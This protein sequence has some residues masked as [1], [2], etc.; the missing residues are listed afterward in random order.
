MSVHHSVHAIVPLALLEAIRNLDTP[1]DDGLP[2]ELASETLTKRLGL[3]STVAAQIERYR[4][5]ATRDT[6]VLSD[7]AIQVFRLVGRRPDATLV[8][9]DAGRR[10]ARYAARRRNGKVPVLR[11]IMPRSLRLRLGVRAATRAARQVF[12]FE[13]TGSGSES[14]SGSNGDGG[15]VVRLTE[16]LATEA[17]F[18]GTGCYFY[19]ALC[20]ELLRVTSGFE[21]SMVHERCL[22][23]GDDSCRWRS[24]EAENW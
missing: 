22:A 7:E 20:A 4:S 8:Y 17:E 12:G 16:S 21:G 1:L 23:R 15:L 24:A 19:G 3:S 11:R 18:V 2:A 13:L 6:P 10:A 9:S 5:M 14:G